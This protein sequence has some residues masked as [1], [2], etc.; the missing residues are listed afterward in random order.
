MNKKGNK[1]DRTLAIERGVHEELVAYRVAMP[2]L[3]N[4]PNI[5]KLN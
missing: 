4:S 5:Y 1:S 2:Y 3:L